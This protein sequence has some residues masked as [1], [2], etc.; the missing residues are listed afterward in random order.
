MRLSFL[1]RNVCY[2]QLTPNKTGKK[3]IYIEREGRREKEG[4]E[5]E[6]GGGGREKEGVEGEER[7][8][9]GG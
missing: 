2:L 4:G 8:T 7:Q 9:R 5:R 3:C 6:K 1:L